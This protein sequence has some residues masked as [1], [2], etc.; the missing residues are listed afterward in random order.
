VTDEEKDVSSYR[1]CI[2][3]VISVGFLINKC[4]GGWIICSVYIEEKLKGK[5]EVTGRRGRRRKQLSV[6]YT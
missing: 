4:F 5:G 2:C 6:L 3:S 1:Y